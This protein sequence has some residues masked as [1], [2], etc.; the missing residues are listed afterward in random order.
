MNCQNWQVGCVWKTHFLKSGHINYSTI[1]LYSR[2]HKGLGVAHYKP[3]PKNQPHFSLM[4][5]RQPS[6][7]PEFFLIIK[8]N[9]LLTD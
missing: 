6:D 7:R 2:D 9:F 1:L 3:S 5:M 8:Q 4:M